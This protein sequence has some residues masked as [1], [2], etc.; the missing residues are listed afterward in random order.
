MQSLAYSYGDFKHDEEKVC[1]QYFDAMLYQN[2]WGQRKLMFRFPKDVVDYKTMRDYRIDGSN[3][4]GYETVLK[5]WQSGDYTLV[6]IEY[7]DEDFE[8]FVEENA[9]SELLDLRSQLIEGDYSCLYAFWLKILDLQEQYNK[10]YYDDD[11]E[12]DFDDDEIDEL[13]A[14]PFGLAKPSSALKSFVEL[15]EIDENLVKAAASFIQKPSKKETDYQV[16]VTDMSEADKTQ[17]LLR[18]VEGETLLD[19]KFK[20]YLSESGTSE[21]GIIVTFEQIRN[22]ALGIK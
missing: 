20:K 21:E 1:E 15:Y 22:K 3:Y 19:V 13:P 18:L 12:D 9:L 17:W 6:V 2:S 14:L 5:I 16:L 4:T 11:D 8:G 7:C 10:E